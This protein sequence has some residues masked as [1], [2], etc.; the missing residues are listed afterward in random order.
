VEVYAIALSESERKHGPE[1]P[2]SQPR[3]PR[4]KTPEQAKANKAARNKEAARKRSEEGKAK[5]KE[6][7]R[8]L[9][10]RRMAAGM[11]ADGKPRKRGGAKVVKPGRKP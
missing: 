6:W 11:R 7:A 2:P 5:R 4:A 8:A 3:R 10:Q 9:R 1:K